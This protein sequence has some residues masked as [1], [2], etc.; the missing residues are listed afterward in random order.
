ML[1]CCFCFSQMSFVSVKFVKHLFI[2]LF[3]QLPDVNYFRCC[4]LQRITINNQSRLRQGFLCLICRLSYYY[5]RSEKIHLN[6]KEFSRRP[7]KDCLLSNLAFLTGGLG[8]NIHSDNY[9]LLLY[10]PRD[11]SSLLN[12]SINSVTCVN[13]KDPWAY[14]NRGKGFISSLFEW[15]FAPRRLTTTPTTSSVFST[16]SSISFPSR[17]EISA[18]CGSRNSKSYKFLNFQLPMGLF[19]P[20]IY[21]KFVLTGLDIEVRPAQRAGER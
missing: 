2:C 8:S 19:V 13:A 9:I 7:V 10:N 18:K 1:C 16:H 3:T 14:E 4:I 17:I 15:H 12:G 21:F 11:W 6:I 5:F 20:G